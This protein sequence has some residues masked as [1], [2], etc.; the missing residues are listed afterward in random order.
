MQYLNPQRATFVRMETAGNRWGRQKVIPRATVSALDHYK[1]IEAMAF[2]NIDHAAR[3]EIFKLVKLGVH[4]TEFCPKDC[5]VLDPA[6]EPT[7]NGFVFWKGRTVELEEEKARAEA[8][9][10][11][12][13]RKRARDTGDRAE[14]RPAKAARRPVRRDDQRPSNSGNPDWPDPREPG[15]TALPVEDPGPSYT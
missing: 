5:L 13:A 15:F 4:V 3:C 8:K 2:L 11:E 1:D 6:S 10:K 12:A 7:C 14:E 9:A